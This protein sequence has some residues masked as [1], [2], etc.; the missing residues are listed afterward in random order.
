MSCY[1]LSLAANF[2]LNSLTSHGELFA[3]WAFL[4]EARAFSAPSNVGNV[5]MNVSV[6]SLLLTTTI[7]AIGV[8]GCVF[9]EV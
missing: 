3:K 1:R 9:D 8:F 5:P 4:S 2:L 6:L 7:F